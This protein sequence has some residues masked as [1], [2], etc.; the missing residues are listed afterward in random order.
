MKKKPKNNVL[1]QRV[2]R[3]IIKTQF[4]G[5]KKISIYIYIGQEHTRKLFKKNKNTHYLIF[6]LNTFYQIR[7]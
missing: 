7:L 3:K 2:H 4:I 6:I 1:L 5:E